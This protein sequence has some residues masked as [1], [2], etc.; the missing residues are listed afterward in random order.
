MSAA[1][2]QTISLFR[3]RSRVASDA[4]VRMRHVDHT[5]RVVPSRTPSS[6]YY[7]WAEG[8]STM[9]ISMWL[10]SAEHSGASAGHFTGAVVQRRA[11]CTT[12]TLILSSSAQANHEAGAVHQID[13]ALSPCVYRHRL[14]QHTANLLGM[15]E[16]DVLIL[17][18]WVERFA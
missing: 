9:P 13:V 15:Y 7:S 16:E 6:R 17:S 3:T 12:G 2:Q 10:P 8:D 11:C 1:Y 5:G 4:R 18:V 14:K